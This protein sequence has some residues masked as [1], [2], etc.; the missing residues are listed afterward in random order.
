MVGR[1]VEDQAGGVVRVKRA[2]AEFVPECLFLV[3]KHAAILIDRAYVCMAGE[4]D[5]SVRIEMDGIMIPQGLQCRIGVLDEC[6]VDCVQVEFKGC[7]AVG[8]VHSA[9]AP[10]TG[11]Q[12]IRPA[13][14]GAF[15]E[16]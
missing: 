9:S 8:Q 3:G 4:I 13:I 7:F 1:I 5:R 14:S 2:I 10:E 11:L 15:P 6:L 16:F 12:I